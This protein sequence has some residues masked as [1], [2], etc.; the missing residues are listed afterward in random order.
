MKPMGLKSTHFI[1][2]QDIDVDEIDLFGDAWGFD[3]EFSDVIELL[4]RL[5]SDP[6]DK[7]TAKLMGR[8][9]NPE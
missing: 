6:Y 4:G 7:L 8:I 2:Y 5:K 3:S 1:S 9:K